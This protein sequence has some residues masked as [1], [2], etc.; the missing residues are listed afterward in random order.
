[1]ASL[2]MRSVNGDLKGRKSFTENL[3]K[4]RLVKISTGKLPEWSSLVQYGTNREV[5]NSIF[6]AGEY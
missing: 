2:Q 4:L 5:E 3:W 6:S 1:M